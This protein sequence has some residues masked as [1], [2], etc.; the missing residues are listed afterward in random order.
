[1]AVLTVPSAKTGRAGESEATVSPNRVTR[2]F[3]EG[4]EHFRR[5]C[6]D[7]HR[8]MLRKGAV[9]ALSL[10]IVFSVGGSR[11]A[12]AD[13]PSPG[14]DCGSAFAEIFTHRDFSYYSRLVRSPFR[15]SDA[16]RDFDNFHKSLAYVDYIGGFESTDYFEDDEVYDAVNSCY[17]RVVDIAR[18]QLD[19]T[20]PLNQYHLGHFLWYSSLHFPDYQRRKQ[21]H[22]LLRRSADAGHS[23][24]I[25]LVG[26]I[27]QTRL[28]GERPLEHDRLI[29]GI[30]F[31]EPGSDEAWGPTVG[32]VLQW[33]ESAGRSGSADAY[34]RLALIYRAGWGVKQ[35]LDRAI[36]QSRLCVWRLRKR[37]L[38]SSDRLT[39]TG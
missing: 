39:G 23:A 30:V 4:S 13:Q 5:V 37:P 14:I 32:E 36:A 31:L 6:G 25:E 28:V 18:G 34:A 17:Q 20:K 33:F 38:R 9:L 35:D 10:A 8:G 22:A 19:L 11:S 16:G 24:A 2:F 29:F 7:R 1:M 27:Y 26:S 12:V 3:R 15:T 21:G